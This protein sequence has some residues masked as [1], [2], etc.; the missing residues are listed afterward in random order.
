MSNI[1]KVTNTHLINN[2]SAINEVSTRI[3]TDTSDSPLSLTALTRVQKD[4]IDNK[5]GTIAAFLDK[6]NSQFIHKHH[7]VSNL[8]GNTLAT[9]E[10][11][12]NH[13]H[14]D[15]NGVAKTSVVNAVNILPHNSIDGL[16][17]P[18]SSLNVTV[19]NATVPMK[20]EDLSSSINAQNAAG[21][22]RS[23]AVTMKGT[24][25]IND[26]PNNSKFLKC[27][28]NGVLQTSEAIDRTTQNVTTDYAGSNLSSSLAMSTATASCDVSN[29]KHI[30]LLIDGVSGSAGTLTLQGSH[31]D[32]DGNFK[33][34]ADMS[35]SSVASTFQYNHKITNAVYKY[36]R[37]KNVI[38]GS[39]VTFT[40]ITFTKL[41]T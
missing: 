18:T 27:D 17:T 41:N 37:I 25:D 19:A 33:N 4:I 15:G 6:D 29:H 12:H 34:V 9:G 2:I 22:S 39:P 36:Y 21:T 5:L 10:G 28:S 11:D 14:I 23:I 7:T 24:S 13:L 8:I 32:V 40:S 26:V 35:S 16:G 31:T 30:H 3:G 38:A 20:L 1:Q